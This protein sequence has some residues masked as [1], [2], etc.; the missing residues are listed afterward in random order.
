MTIIGISLG[1][2]RT[3]VC[4]IRDGELLEEELH[5]H[6]FDAQ[7]SEKK[8]HDIAKAYRKY[9]R[10]YPVTGIMVKIP[11]LDRH[12]GP[13]TALLARVE[14]LAG[15]YGCKYDLI[16][17]SELKHFTGLHSTNEIVELS[18]RLYPVLEPL[19]QKGRA[20]GHSYN[21]KIFEAVLSAHVFRQWQLRRETG[22]AHTTK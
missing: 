15:E 11:P 1:T 13:I 10:K 9:L 18:R 5:L 2:S 6:A 22:T 21:G 7:W 20:N 12:T 17:K 4:I 16:T 8:L 19:Y 14:S 3:A